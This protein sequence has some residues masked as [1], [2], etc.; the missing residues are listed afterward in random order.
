MLIVY[1]TRRRQLERSRVA[2]QELPAF[3]IAD[4]AGMKHGREVTAEPVGRHLAAVRRLHAPEDLAAK[5]IGTDKVALR[6]RLTVPRHGS[7]M[8][9]LDLLQFL[10][11]P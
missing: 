2:L 10:A 5:D 1:N 7:Q 3:Q 6:H 11:D 4:H 9:R 8:K